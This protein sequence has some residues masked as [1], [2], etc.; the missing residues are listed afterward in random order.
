MSEFHITQLLDTATVTVR[1]VHCLGSE[2][3]RTPLELSA[4]TQVVFPY[5]GVYVRHVGRDEI[6]A[7]PNQALFF[8]ASDPYQVSHPVAG[9]DASIAIGVTEE[10]FRELTPREILRYARHFAFEPKRVPLK[11]DVPA[12]VALLRLKLRRGHIDLLEAESL[13]LTALRS[14]LGTFDGKPTSS[15]GS[16]LVDRAKLLMASDVARRWS[17][18]DVASEV[19]CS[20]VYLTQLFKRIEGIPLHRFHLRL[21]LAAALHRIG[22]YDDLTSL[23]LDLGFSSHS[24]FTASFVREYGCPPSVFGKG[25]RSLRSW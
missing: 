8:N 10:T 24:H 22:D 5:R 17:L 7:E 11:G 4:T 13:T 3:G 23:A 18:A 14:V 19:N 1:D 15:A 2:P 25:R 6:V 12:A 21:K 16:R 9:G 20:P